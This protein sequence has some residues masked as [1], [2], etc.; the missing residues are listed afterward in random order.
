M[1][2][3]SNLQNKILMWIMRRARDEL[4]QLSDPSSASMDIYRTDIPYLMTLA[5]RQP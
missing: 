2:T 5:H 4:F 1:I 3:S